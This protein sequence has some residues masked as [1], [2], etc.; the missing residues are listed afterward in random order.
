[1]PYSAAVRPTRRA[2]SPRLAMRMDCN[3]FPSAEVEDAREEAFRYAVGKVREMR[4][5]RLRSI[6]WIWVVEATYYI[7]QRMDAYIREGELWRYSTKPSIAVAR[8]L[9]QTGGA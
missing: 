1:M 6:V 2:I 3:G 7:V 5:A 8:G 9:A 4:E